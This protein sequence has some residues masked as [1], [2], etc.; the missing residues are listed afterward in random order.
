MSVDPTLASVELSVVVAAR[1][2]E[3]FELFTSRMAEWWPLDVASYGGD[4]AREIFLEP[5][6][7]GRFFERF[8]DG[9]SFRSAL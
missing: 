1:V 2:A 6:V 3:A 4:R 9:M 8:T 7:G 5:R